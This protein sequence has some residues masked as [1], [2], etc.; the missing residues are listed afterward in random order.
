[1]RTIVSAG[2]GEQGF[3]EFLGE[4]RR[5]AVLNQNEKLGWL[6]LHGALLRARE[7]PLDDGSGIDEEWL[8]ALA[9]ELGGELEVRDTDAPVGGQA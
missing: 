1:M 9:R 2:V 8:Q 6:A 4:L 5:L 3:V 7:V